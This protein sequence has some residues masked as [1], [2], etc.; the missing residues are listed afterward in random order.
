MGGVDAL[1]ITRITREVREQSDLIGALG[2]WLS[3][4]RTR[5]WEQV[6]PPGVPAGE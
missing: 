5:C 6:L 4:Y 2:H 1:Y 3:V